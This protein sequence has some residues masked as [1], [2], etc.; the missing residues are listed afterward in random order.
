MY[1]QN[2][3]R[4]LMIEDERQIDIILESPDKSLYVEDDRGYSLEKQRIRRFAAENPEED[5]LRTRIKSAKDVNAEILQVTYDFFFGGRVRTLFPDS[6]KTVKAFKIIHDLAKEYGLKFSASISNP[7]DLGRGYV[8]NHDEVGYTWHYREGAIDDTGFYDVKMPMQTQWSNNKGPIRLVLDKI[9]VYAFHE[10]RYKDTTYF[11]VN[12]D[13]ILD[14]SETAKLEIMG[15]EEISKRGNGSMPVRVRGQWKD[16]KLGYNR[17]LV[18]LVYRTQELDYFSE[19]AL[20]Y[21]KGIIDLHAEAGI[22]YQ[23]FYSDEMHI[24]FDWDSNVH[25]ASTE[26]TTRYLTPNLAKRYAKLYGEEFNDFGKYLVYFAYNQHGF[27]KDEKD[28]PAQH[29]MFPGEEGIYKTWLF[30]KR[31][32]ELLNDVVVDLCVQ[33]KKYAE[34]KFGNPIDAHGHATWK[35]SPTLD[36]NYPEMKWYSLR[37]DDMFSR[38]D[39]HPEY[40]ASSSIIEAVAGCYDYFRWNDYFTGGGTDHGEHGYSDRNYYTQAFGA[41]LGVLNESRHG[42]A[43]GWGSP[44]PIIERMNAVGRTYGN[45]GFRG[46]STDCFVQNMQH[47]KTDVLAVY[48]LDLLYTEERFGSWMV[49]YGYC[50]YITEAKLLEHGKVTNGVLDVKGCKYRALVFL[51]QSF[52]SEKTIDLIEKFIAQGGRVLWMATPPAL[53]WETGKEVERWQNIFGVSYGRDIFNGKTAKGK[54]IHFA[55]EIGTADMVIPTDFLPDYVYQVNALNAKPIAWLEGMPVGF[56]K[57]YGSGGHAV[58]LA[59]R[60]RDDQ[61]QSMG[62]DISTLFDV[63]RYMGSYS[64]DGGEIISRPAGA[65]YLVNRFPNGAVSMAVHYRTFNEYWPGLYGRDPKQDEEYLKGRELPSMEIQLSQESMFDNTITYHGTGT[66]T[67]NIVDGKLWGF[68]GYG[69]CITING[70]TYSFA[71]P[72]TDFCFVNVD[73]EHLNVKKAVLIYY[74][75]AGRVTIPNSAG[76]QSPKAAVCKLNVMEPEHEIPV[77]FNSEKLSVVFDVASKGKWIIIWEE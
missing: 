41:S 40:V 29:I 64:P 25:F 74:D 54:S 56:D 3:F 71:Q 27:D 60:A 35:E 68:A 7:L 69:G 45:S 32:F 34:E 13:E 43:G 77:D 26:V 55:D 9:V 30:R 51:Y 72:G 20:R 12:P 62:A 47:R 5:T 44:V 4:T 49:Q 73:P 21:M 8:I 22:T 66:L 50:N 6:E 19:G 15:D 31:Y 63:L 52:V 28:I 24:Q 42:Y 14:I 17:C 61:S 11:Y 46:V 33:M 57:K 67:Y 76:L 75:G 48:P 1:R 53:S 37:R 10:E 70:T 16:I 58:Y 38:Y 23:G 59:F 2:K 65:R 18:V 36:K 39:Y